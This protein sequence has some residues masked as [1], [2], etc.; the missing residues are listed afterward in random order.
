MTPSPSTPSAAPA[1]DLTPNRVIDAGF[2]GRNP[3]L[4]AGWDSLPTAVAIARADERHA[5]AIATDPFPVRR[6]AQFVS[7][8]MRAANLAW[9]FALECLLTPC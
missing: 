3:D 6:R 9:V 7:A 8:N 5:L 1:L 4:T 2:H